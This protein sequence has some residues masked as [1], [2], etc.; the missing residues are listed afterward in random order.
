MKK[1]LFTIA[2]FAASLANALFAQQGNLDSTFNSNGIVITAISGSDQAFSIAIQSDGKIVVAGES[3]PIGNSDFTVVRYNSDGS[4][5][6]NFGIGGKVTTDVVTGKFDYARSAAIQADGKIVVAGSTT[7]GTNY[8]WALVRY[9]T[10]G[11]L[12][13]TFSGDGKLTTSLS[14][15]F[16]EAFAVAIQNDGKIVVGGYSEP[17]RAYYALARYNSNGTLDNT[18]SGDGKVTTAVGT[19]SDYI[20]SIAIQPDGKII[21][22]GISSDGA[23][24]NDFSLARYN[25]DGSLDTS[26]SS[27]GK[28]ITSIGNGGNWTNSVKIQPDGKIIICGS[29][30]IGNHQ[31]FTMLRYNSNGTFDSI[32]GAN[33]IVITPIDT[34]SDMAYSLALQSD[35]KIIMAGT[36]NNGSDDDFALIRYNSNGSIDSTFGINGIVTTA[37]GTDDDV[38]LSA[39][40]QQNGNIILAGYTRNYPDMYFAVA[41]YVSGLNIGI[42]DFSIPNN[43]VLIYPNPVKQN[44]TLE[45]EL[46]DQETISIRLLDIQGR[47]IKTFIGNEKQETGKHQQSINFPD[48]LPSGYYFIS[49]SSESGQVSLK[50]VK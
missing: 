20:N 31:S 28:L 40:I 4:L 21:A 29:S 27:D 36:S 41:R 49:I 26:F 19:H 17:T 1:I 23:I 11:T 42:I 14:S 43:S 44:A 24:Y 35:G 38:A 30:V 8:D 50:I 34:N 33:G 9:K 15:G 48:E 5:D 13:S 2:I 22:A 37:I 46:K 18:F 10:D 16:D 12:D 3:R 47:C 45:Y 32:F 39:A 25:I 6:N 7:T